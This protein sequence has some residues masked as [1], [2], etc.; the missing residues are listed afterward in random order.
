MTLAEKRKTSSG[1]IP[2]RNLPTK[3]GFEEQPEKMTDL[4]FDIK[5]PKCGSRTLIHLLNALMKK[6]NFTAKTTATIPW[7]KLRLSEQAALVQKIQRFRRPAIF[8]HQTHFINFRRFGVN[9]PTYISIIR[10]PLSRLVSGYYYNIFGDDHRDK[11]YKGQYL[12]LTFD[13]CVLQDYPKCSESSDKFDFRIIP[14]F[15]GHE[16]EC[17]Q[18]TRWSLEKAKENVEKYFIIVGLTEEYVNTIRLFEK[19]MPRFFDGALSI[20][21]TPG[22]LPNFT[23]NNKIEP[24]AKVVNIMNQRLSLEN[25]FYDFIRQR[26]YDL[27]TKYGITGSSL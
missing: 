2:G 16:K 4:V 20:L 15:C 19:M 24:S 18:H 8:Y 27:K 13:E 23:T 5:V 22:S 12:N 9:N 14:F 21:E 10:Q 1:F 26:Y 17:M 7:G 3:V 25:E 11:N 6:N